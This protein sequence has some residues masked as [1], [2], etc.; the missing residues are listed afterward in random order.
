M[1]KKQKTLPNTGNSL[2]KSGGFGLLF[3]A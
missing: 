3:L 1:S 2:N